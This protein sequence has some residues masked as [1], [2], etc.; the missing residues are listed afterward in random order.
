MS[1]HKK[2][3]ILRPDGTMKETTISNLDDMQAVVDG[4]IELFFVS[5]SGID[6]Y[7]DEEF[8]YK[9]KNPNAWTSR[10]IKAGYHGNGEYGIHGTILAVRHDDEGET[11]SLTSEDIMHLEALAR[12]EGV[13]L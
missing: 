8:L 9:D 5:K 13:T 12:G 4:Y 11:T 6:F 7:C 10:L 1:Q 2:A 3:A